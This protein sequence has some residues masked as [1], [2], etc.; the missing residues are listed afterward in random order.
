MRSP[1][2]RPCCLWVIPF[3]NCA[4]SWYM[5]L[6][7]SSRY[8]RVRRAARRCRRCRRCR[9]FGASGQHP[10]RRGR[11]RRIRGAHRRADVGQIRCRRSQ[12]LRGRHQIRHPYPPTGSPTHRQEHSVT[13][14]RPHISAFP[15][16]V[17][18]GKTAGPGRRGSPNSPF[19]VSGFGRE[20]AISPLVI[21]QAPPGAGAVSPTR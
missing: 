15:P 8:S 14:S 11:R 16:S 3:S 17:L 10:G 19:G 1:R 13:P 2:P 6:A 5:P 12:K 7:M 18:A 9:V 4:G 20:E 21:I